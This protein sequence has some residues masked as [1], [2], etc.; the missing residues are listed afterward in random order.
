MGGLHSAL[1]LIP[2]TSNL[3]PKPP[4]QTYLDDFVIVDAFVEAVT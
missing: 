3:T 2:H 1:A 4:L